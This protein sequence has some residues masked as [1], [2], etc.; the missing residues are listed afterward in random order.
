MT[1]YN[2]SN[3][4]LQLKPNLE[5]P[6]AELNPLSKSLLKSSIGLNAVITHCFEMSTSSSQPNCKALLSSIGHLLNK[7]N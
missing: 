3:I 4:F 6:I 7:Q 1:Q 2:K 5:I